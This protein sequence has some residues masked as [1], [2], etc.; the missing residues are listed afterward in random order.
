VLNA[1]HD[2]VLPE[3]ALALFRLLPKA[4]LEILPGGHGEYLGEIGSQ[5]PNSPLPQ[6]VVATIEEFLAR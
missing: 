2:V 5:H 3:Q 1:D 6:L 4:Q